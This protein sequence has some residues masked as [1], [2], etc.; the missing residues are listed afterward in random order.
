MDNGPAYASKAFAEF[1][2]IWGI[3]HV[4]GI[5]Y[6]PQGQAIAEHEHYKLKL[7]LKK[8]KREQ[9]YPPHTQDY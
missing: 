9:E 5:P 4:T 1:C 8:Q 7:Q 6:N 3:L 2:Q